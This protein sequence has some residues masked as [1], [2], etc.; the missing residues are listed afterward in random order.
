MKSAKKLAGCS[1]KREDVRKL[2][3]YFSS[4]ALW[5]ELTLISGP[6]EIIQSATSTAKIVTLS[7]RSHWSER[8]WNFCTYTLKLL[9]A[10]RRVYD[11]NTFRE[12]KLQECISNGGMILGKY[13]DFHGMFWID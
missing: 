12:S 13:A 4:R 8:I 1:K 11:Q 3:S 7:I 5:T 9:E 6:L 10:P 2:T